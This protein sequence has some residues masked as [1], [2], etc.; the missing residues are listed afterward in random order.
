MTL[1]KLHELM[2]KNGWTMCCSVPSIGK[3]SYSKDNS[4]V[5][6]TR[7]YRDIE[8][9]CGRVRTEPTLLSDATRTTY[10]ELAV[11]EG[12]RKVGV[13]SL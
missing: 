4:H 13:M 9:K 11:Y 10:G 2:E 5:M 1:E 7:D 12:T 8:L 6:I 3:V